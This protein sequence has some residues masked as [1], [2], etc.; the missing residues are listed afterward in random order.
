[1]WFPSPK[2]LET[3]NSELEIVKLTQD[4]QHTMSIA[5][6]GIWNMHLPQIKGQ[7]E[8]A[9]TTGSVPYKATDMPQDGA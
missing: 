4:A 9:A 8:C 2:Q 6:I 5:E 1:M 7:I 3:L